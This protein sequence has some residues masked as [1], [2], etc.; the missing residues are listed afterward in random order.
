MMEQTASGQDQLVEG[1]DASLLF[2]HASQ[3]DLE[4]Y[5]VS[6][7]R[8]TAA[9]AAREIAA[10][11]ADDSGSPR[12][13]VLDSDAI[14]PGGQ[15][16]SILAITDRN[17]P[18]LYDSVMGEVTGT[19]RDML[20]AIHPIVEIGADGQVQAFDAEA[21][22][23]PSRRISH[24]QLH[25]PRLSPAEADALKIRIASV[26]AQVHVAVGDWQ[27]MID[28]LDDAMSALKA[29]APSKR[30]GDRKETLAFLK[31][32]RD[33]NFTFLG[34]RE[35]GYSGEGETAVLERGSGHGLGILSDPDVRVLRLGRDAVVT[36][37]EILAFL[38][39]PDF[40]IVTKANVKSVVHRRTYMDYVGIKRFDAE[41]RVIGELRIVGLFASSAYA[42]PVS[43][44]PLIRQ[45]V[46]RVVEHFGFDPESHSGKML[47]NTLE[48][49]PRDDLFQIDT[50]LLQAFCGQINE[51][52]DRPRVRV[53][54]R[55][56][57]FDRFVSVLVYVPREQYD[58]HV[59]ERIGLY[60]KTVYDGRVSAFYP[61]FPAGGL[62]RVHFIIGR[63]SGKTPDVPQRQLEA[64][65]RDI[66]TSW[67][68][69]LERLV[70]HDH[71]TLAA[72]DAYQAAFAPEEAYGDLPAIRA[73]TPEDPIRIS[74]YQRS[75]KE[76]HFLELKIFHAERPVPLSKRVPLLENLGFSVISEQTHE[77]TVTDG[78][79]A[80]LVIVHDMELTHR[81]GMALDLAKA[82]ARLENAFL[83][84]WTGLVE[85]DAYNRL[86]LL[87]GLTARE[88]TILRGYARYLR[89]AG[90][91]YSQDYIAETLNKY[92]PLAA[93]LV[94][95]FLARMDPTAAP[96]AREE[97][98]NRRLAALEE[99]LNAVPSLDEDQILRRHLNAVLATL[100]TNYFQQDA[101]GASPAMLAMKLDPKL[102][103]GLPEPRPFRE[104]FV[105]GTEVE[106]VHLR[107][108]KVARGGLRWSDRAQDY[109]TEVLGLVKAQQVK[110]AVIV[111]VGAKG[112]FYPKQL[113]AGGS[114]D[115]VFAA[116]T[117]AY[118]TYIRT[119]LS[120][121]DNIVDQSVIPPE[122]T[123][124]LDEDDPYFVVAADKG[125]AT[126]S[127][128]ANGLAQ[129]A[130]FWL[131][132]AFASGG[133]AGYDH[134]KMGITARGAWE[135]V[136]RH[137]REMDVD[138][139]RMPFTVAGVGDMSGDVFGNG[140]L[141]SRQIHLIAAFDHR[142]I[143]I[144]PTPNNETS[145]AER[146]RLF[147]LPR[148]SWQ[149]YDRSL[150]SEGGMIISRT[151][152]SVRLTTQAAERLGLA[153]T[154]ATPA[155]IM[156][157]ILK[158]PVDLL[159]F[160]GIGTYVRAPGESDAEAGD[161]AND[162]I[163]ISADEVGA[164]VIGEGAN[165]GVTQRG[166]IAYALKGGRCNSDAIDNSAGVNS[167]D[168][169]VNIKI[170]LAFAL[171]DGRLTREARNVLLAS[172]TDEVA[173]LVLRNNYL[174]SLAIS[175]TERQGA[176]N[177]TPLARL[178]SRLEA[179][180]RLNRKVEFL[181][182]EAALSERYQSGK[183]LTR[184]EIGVLLSYAKIVLFDDVLDSDLPDDAYFRD[185]L[186]GYFPA[187]MH[188]GHEGDI[189]AH[190]LKREIIATVLANET[191]NRGG[192]AFVT[193]LVDRTG[194]LPSDVV[195]AGVLAR[196]GFDL[197][198][199]YARIDA[200]DTQVG[201]ALHN[202]LYE[203]V[204][205]IFAVVTE[206]ALRTR[207]VAGPLGAAVNRLRAALIE[208]KAALED[209]IS[210]EALNFARSRAEALMAEGAP[211]DIAETIAT[212]LPL[213]LVPEILQISDDT[214]VSLTRTAQS[215]FAVTERLKVGQLLVSAERVTFTDPYEA[216]AL[217]RS[218]GDLA[219]ARRAIT[220]AALTAHKDE[221]DPVAAWQDASRDRVQRVAADLTTLTG[222]G[223]ATLAKL[224]VA[225]GLLGDLA[226][227]PA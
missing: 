13:S 167:S 226:R 147:A 93:E 67:S 109:R 218:I 8:Q 17:M 36:T 201:G 100:R 118:K 204:G 142:D 25:L 206:R 213:T 168:V 152:K 179:I 132:D 27:A 214:G 7:R 58:S 139:Q 107:F 164:K 203:D 21:H 56:D 94:R 144:D 82:G 32:L 188:A 63:T 5:D 171:K 20:L 119:L 70:R 161:K 197:G 73:V 71:V 6:M 189:L 212:L 159:W 15:P 131:D 185:T 175:L 117:E 87:A 227:P 24:I 74:F 160:G 114:R 205:R 46:E 26:L 88:V 219:Q 9:I 115:A 149:D 207:I 120:I 125:T 35:Y 165:L 187:T 22:G 16:V 89:Q 28:R 225:A 108:G 38:Q 97:E 217:S 14:A 199:L 184:P 113:P 153:Q 127:D 30:K 83:A 138:I 202:S 42:L 47:L 111:P 163:R 169:E 33:D 2:A 86:V 137:F 181:P 128:T 124:R 174:Q 211:A 66:V 19:Y 103:D 60:L 143:F 95:L 183:A 177:R 80:R 39:G 148:S 151:E 59:R 162:A 4:A 3:D 123:L 99:G 43:E 105:Y 44:I 190:P 101:A 166:R 29:N 135:T 178:M 223:E 11:Q 195:K 90:I 84:A 116:G 54:V 104:I 69:R 40:L 122:N 57:R 49:Y 45:K 224:S 140:M 34:M 52:S 77:L 23:D 78:Q 210:E 121:T 51:L 76:S 176:A 98:V 10:H 220:V 216:M 155:E 182:S 146:E 193:S 106:G 41:G 134:K 65:V 55:A 173:H 61:A 145:F 64:A 141:L 209:S 75:N 79:G 110:N 91:T 130:G 102:L 215:Y 48:S 156:T 85:D 126:F 170:A 196:D 208:L 112:G 37:P 18:F 180:G 50:E 136:K 154:T 133:S 157:A 31:W 1:I 81:D 192:P 221:E 92:A 53:L 158:A 222:K 129:E 200:L 198:A 186:L 62:A 68:D 12:I 172:M 194:V 72:G 150:L 96:E 191:I